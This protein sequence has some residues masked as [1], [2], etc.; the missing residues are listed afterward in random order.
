MPNVLA[1]VIV[2]VTPS[3][4]TAILAEATLSFL[5]LGT[6]PPAPS[7]GTM[8]AAGQK[9]LDL[10]PWLTLFPGLAIMLAVLGSPGRRAP[11]RPGPPGRPAARGPGS[12]EQREATCYARAAARGR[13]LM[14]R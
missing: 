9:F 1:P 2:Q 14:P 4:S 5:G 8:L 11:G 7:W 6:R 12:L 13:G 10:A 3:F